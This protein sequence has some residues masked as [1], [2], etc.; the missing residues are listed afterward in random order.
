MKETKKFFAK[1]VILLVVAI[2]IFLLGAFNEA[3]PASVQLENPPIETGYAKG[4]TLKISGGVYFIRDVLFVGPA[5]PGRSELKTFPD[6]AVQTARAFYDSAK[7]HGNWVAGHGAADITGWSR[8]RY[9][10]AEWNNLND[11]AASARLTSVIKSVGPLDLKLENALDLQEDY[12]GAFLYELEVIVQPLPDLANVMFVSDLADSQDVKAVVVGRT[13]KDYG[14]LTL[15][16]FK[17]GYLE[18]SNGKNGKNGHNG[19]TNGQSHAYKYELGVANLNQVYPLP[20]GWSISAE[21]YVEGDSI[22]YRPDLQNFV[23]HQEDDL[24]HIQGEPRL[25]ETPE[26]ITVVNKS[27]WSDFSLNLGVGVSAGDYSS[28]PV[29]TGGLSYKNLLTIDLGY[30]PFSTSNDKMSLQGVETDL[31]DRLFFGNILIFPFKSVPLGVG[32]SYQRNETRASKFGEYILKQEG[33]YPSIRWHQPLPKGWLGHNWFV[34]FDLSATPWAEKKSAFSDL[35]ETGQEDV[36]L[37][38]KLTKQ[39][40]GKKNE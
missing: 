17:A 25:K 19:E 9:R 30:S 4:D 38:L 31:R 13:Q 22:G 10:E 28:G 29:V 14:R 1:V 40:G 6:E 34:S 16:S 33:L 35:V 24:R 36:R 12:R 27:F 7:A 3:S 23:L 21:F 20:I 39:F 18:V 11:N 5:L 2:V 26:Q 8:K 37:T 32:L 15:D